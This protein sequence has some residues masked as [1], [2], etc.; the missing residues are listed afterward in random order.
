MLASRT[1]HRYLQLLIEWF[2]ETTRGDSRL[3]CNDPL[4]P[5][6]VQPSPFDAFLSSPDVFSH[7]PASMRPPTTLPPHFSCINSR[8]LTSVMA[9]DRI[10]LISTRLYFRSP[11]YWNK[12]VFFSCAGFVLL[13]NRTNFKESFNTFTDSNFILNKNRSFLKSDSQK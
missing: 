13:I 4:F 10:W 2:V 12:L 6:F 11:R 5:F 7:I 9:T 1:Y 3:Q 8:P